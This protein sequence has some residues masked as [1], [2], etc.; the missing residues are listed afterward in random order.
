MARCTQF[1]VLDLGSLGLGFQ[2]TTPDDH[3]QLEEEEKKRKNPARSSKVGQRNT[4]Q[5]LRSDFFFVCVIEGNVCG[6]QQ[7]FPF[8]LKET[9]MYGEKD[10]NQSFILI[11]FVPFF[12]TK[13]SW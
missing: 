10:V 8:F 5:L 3:A 11:H 7:L 1:L 13:E 2:T 6:N 12:S 4:L 9:K